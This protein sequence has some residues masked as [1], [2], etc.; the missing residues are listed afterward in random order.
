[1]K[2]LNKQT[3]S[4]ALISLLI[5]SAFTLILGLA[6]AENSISTGYQYVNNTSGEAS[7][8]GAEGCL[9]E[10]VIRIENDSSFTSET[11]SFDWGTCQIV[12]TGTN[13]KTVDVTITQGVYS[14]TYQATVDITVNGHATNASL[15][16]WEEI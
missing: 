12:V 4:I 8:Y 6:M 10:A 13:P 3:G 9:E 14:E 5:I 16:S 7:Y 15:S 1:M 11:I 2:I